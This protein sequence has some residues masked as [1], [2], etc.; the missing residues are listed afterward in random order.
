[1]VLFKPGNK[2]G[3]IPL[4]KS[5]GLEISI[6]IFPARFLEPARISAVTELLPCVAFITSS[7]KVAASLKEPSLTL[8]FDLNHSLKEGLP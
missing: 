6:R 7:P 4:L 5:R 1:L 8:L 3:G 2:L